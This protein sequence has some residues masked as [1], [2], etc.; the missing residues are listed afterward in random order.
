MAGTRT[1]LNSNNL[2]IFLLG[3]LGFS[4]ACHNLG[5]EYGVPH[6]D[7]V[8]KGSVISSMDN[9]GIE[10]IQLIMQD[11]VNPYNND[12]TYTDEKG[13][14]ELSMSDFPTDLTVKVSLNDIDGTANGE[15]L[16]LDTLVVFK[17][18]KFTGGNSDWYN[19]KTE[20][21]VNIALKPKK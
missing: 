1:I 11:T 18:P 12:T 9:K 5:T 8:V 2:I 19:G 20:K 7:F 13:N 10:N 4:T 16:P 15:Y 6:A 21:I 14:Y 17:D 3:L